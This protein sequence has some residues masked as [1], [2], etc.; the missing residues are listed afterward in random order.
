MTLET[1]RRTLAPVIALT[2]LFLAGSVRPA[3]A[4]IT[5][6]LGLSPTPAR[7]TVKGFSGGLSLLVV[8]YWLQEVQRSDEKDEPREI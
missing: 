5:A 2:V 3:H 1:R 4:D 8:G 7:H 6:F